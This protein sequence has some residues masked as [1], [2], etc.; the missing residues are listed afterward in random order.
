MTTRCHQGAPVGDV[1]GL[2]LEIVQALDIQ[3]CLERLHQKRPLSGQW[4]EDENPRFEGRSHSV[5][6][7]KIT[8]LVFNHDFRP[9]SCYIRSGPSETDRPPTRIRRSAPSRRQTRQVSSLGGLAQKKRA[10]YP[11]L[12]SSAVKWIDLFGGFRLGLL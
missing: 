2:D 4:A 5:Y 7:R 1:C 12:R 11:A 3:R 6:A 8:W 10:G 9:P